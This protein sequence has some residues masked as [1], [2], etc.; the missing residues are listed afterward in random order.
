MYDN[1]VK[2]GLVADADSYNGWFFN[3]DFV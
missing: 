2:S 3:P 1:P